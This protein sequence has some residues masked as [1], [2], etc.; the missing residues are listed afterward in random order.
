[1]IVLVNAHRDRVLTEPPHPPVAGYRLAVLLAPPNASCVDASPTL[2]RGLK[3]GSPRAGDAEQRA[4]TSSVTAASLLVA[5]IR[6]NP[7]IRP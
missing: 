6:S 1:M 5:T 2:R 7:S 3:C 4:E